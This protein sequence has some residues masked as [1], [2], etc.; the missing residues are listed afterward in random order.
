VSGQGDWAIQFN[1]KGFEKDSAPQILTPLIPVAFTRLPLPS[2]PQGPPRN[3]NTFILLVARPI[4]PCPDIMSWSSY[5]KTKA[6]EA[7]SAALVLAASAQE[8]ASNFSLDNLVDPNLVAQAQSQQRDGEVTHR[9]GGLNYTYVRDRLVAMSFPG[10]GKRPT[11][12]NID[13]VASVLKERHAGQFMIWNLS[14]EEYDYQMFDSQVQEFKFPGHPAPP[15]AVMFQ[16]INSMESWLSADPENVA[17]VHCLTGRGR[18]VT[19]LAC[20]LAWVGEFET[21]TEALSFVCEQRHVEMERV[22]IPSQIRYVHYFC[23]VMAGTKPRSE[24]LLLERVIVNTIP[25]FCNPP[26]Q[27]QRQDLIAKLSQSGASEEAAQQAA[28]ASVAPC[29]GCCPYLQ[30]FQEGK[31]LFSST[32][33]LMQEGASIPKYYK[34]DGSFSFD[35]NT[36]LYGDVLVRCRHVDARTGKRVSM[37]RAGFHTGYIPQLVQRLPRSQCDGAVHDARFETDFFVDLIFAPAPT[38][39]PKT[40]TAKQSTQLPNTFWNEIAKRKERLRRVQSKKEHA[41]VAGGGGGEA[42]AGAGAGAGGEKNGSSSTTGRSKGTIINLESPMRQRRL[43]EAKERQLRARQRTGSSL[44]RAVRNGTGTV[45]SN[46]VGNGTKADSNGQTSRQGVEMDGVTVAP[47]SSKKQAFSLHDEDEEDEYS[48]PKSSKRRKE[49]E[50]DKKAE[51]AL[52]ADLVGAMELVNDTLTTDTDQNLDEL[53]QLEAEL[54]LEGDM[55]VTNSLRDLDK[56]IRTT[57][58]STSGATASTAATTTTTTTAAAPGFSTD[59]SPDA[60]AISPPV[61][62]TAA[63][64][65]PVPPSAST[66]AIPTTDNT[67]KTT[68]TPVEDV[69]VDDFDFDDLSA[70]L[71][72]MGVSDDVAFTD[73]TALD[74]LDDFLAGLDD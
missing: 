11:E 48:S 37:F 22:V 25:T 10:S 60:V 66:D 41:T 35:V 38:T 6:A 19:V 52:D 20:F 12:N 70:E 62:A 24:P 57:K 51:M 42:G 43:A 68:E 14:E 50:E 71:E 30:I 16:I 31:V 32:W 36:V 33:A 13:H 55:A 8:A 28:F 44:L 9:V 59:A 53:A 15:L 72:G 29:D 58:D 21:A 26:T 73:D 54:G 2:T 46:G 3:N 39:D 4:F 1:F 47:R 5:F 61:V 23:N 65:P 7:Q 45:P 56:V 64:T 40:P 67:K 27:Q 18:T 17:I 49:E 69:D 63:A 34:S 74:D